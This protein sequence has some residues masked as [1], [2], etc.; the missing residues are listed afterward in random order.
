MVK[1]QAKETPHL[2][3]R[4]EPKLLSKL[5][6]SRE[7]N[8]NT[9]TGEIVARLEQSFQADDHVAKNLEFLEQRLND[10]KDRHDEK[11]A[12]VRDQMEKAQAIA[13]E[14]LKDNERQRAEFE[15]IERMSGEAIRAASVVDVLLGSNKLKSDLLRSFALELAE[16][17][18]DWLVNESNGRQLADRV[19]AGFEKDQAGEAGQ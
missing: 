7:K 18:E 8:G 4:I 15:Q 5:E 12:A 17:P 3:I 13:E 2:R 16:A 11:L 1:K 9:L 14:A 19:F 10:Y 6:K